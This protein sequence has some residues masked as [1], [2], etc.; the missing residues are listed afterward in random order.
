MKKWLAV[1]I[2]VLSSYVACAKLFTEAVEL[3]GKAASALGLKV[4]KE[5]RVERAKALSAYELGKTVV[6]LSLW[7]QQSAASH[8][9]GRS[10]VALSAVDA[11]A[12]ETELRLLASSLAI[13]NPESLKDLDFA[14]R[15]EGFGYRG[16]SAEEVIQNLIPHDESIFR[17]AYREGVRVQATLLKAFEG[18]YCCA[19]YES[20]W[21]EAR[22]DIEALDSGSY[23]LGVARRNDELL[24]SREFN[25]YVKPRI[26]YYVSIRAQQ[27]DQDITAV[28]R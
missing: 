8:D 11:A 26:G 10:L 5:R 2:G 1:M 24:R 3:T 12:E 13:A 25:F 7:H 19:D 28:L 18:Q 14:S 27:D 23:Q 21:Q 20:V 15:V 16:S 4:G 9:A 17:Q 22:G 6:W